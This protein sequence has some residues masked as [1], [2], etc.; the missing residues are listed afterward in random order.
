MQVLDDLLP[1]FTRAKR[2]A[3]AQKQKTERDSTA[4]TLPSS[5]TGPDGGAGGAKAALDGMPKSVS[6]N[7]TIPLVSGHVMKIPQHVLNISD[8]VRPWTTIRTY[9]NYHSNS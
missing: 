7:L 5:A 4:T 1:E 2:E 3:A 9:S 6:G 8:E